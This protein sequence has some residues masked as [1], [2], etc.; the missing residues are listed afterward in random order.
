MSRRLV[1]VS[2]AAAMLG[3]SDRQV[4]RHIQTGAVATVRLGHRR[5]ISV[6]EVDRIA[7]EGC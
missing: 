1:S 5:M 6:A 4:W 7:R 2:E 3:L